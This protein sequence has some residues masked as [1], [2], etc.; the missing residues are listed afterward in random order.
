[1]KNKMSIA[2]LIVFISVMSSCSKPKEFGDGFFYPIL[3]CAEGEVFLDGNL[4]DYAYDLSKGVRWKIS[5]THTF[6]IPK[7][8]A[9][10][11]PEHH[12][13]YGMPDGKT[14][15]KVC[16]TDNTV[17]RWESEYMLL[18]KSDD[19]TW[20]LTVSPIVDSEKYVAFFIS[21][22]SAECRS[23]RPEG[24]PWYFYGVA[25][26]KPYIDRP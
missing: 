20:Y 8:I 22:Q 24:E 9:I 1:M 17:S 11:G 10:Q 25:N 7:V 14:I 15:D 19:H 2:W 23:I 6:T 4:C 21:A 12:D 26:P 16:T 18:E 5:S 13:K 3:Q